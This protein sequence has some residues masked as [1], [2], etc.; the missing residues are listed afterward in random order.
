[1]P[2]TFLVYLLGQSNADGP[3][4]TDVGDL[5]VGYSGE[6]ENIKIWDGASNGFVNLDTALNNNQYPASERD[7]GFAIEMGML[8]DL[9]EYTGGQVY[10]IKYA[11]PGTPKFQRD[12]AD[13]NVGSVDDLFQ[14]AINEI[15][16]A[17]AWLTNNNILY[18]K[19][20]KVEWQGESDAL[21]T[22][23]D[24]QA[25]QQNNI[26]FHSAINT[27]IG[28]PMIDTILHKVHEDINAEASRLAA[29]RTAFDNI[30]SSELIPSVH[31]LN[32]DAFDLADNYHL[33]SADMLTQG[34]NVALEL[35]NIVQNKFD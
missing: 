13:W 4:T 33:D 9:A 32:V 23:A 2:H 24:A 3:P 30:L 19:L 10:C 18:T 27:Q 21:G 29:V 31:L 14:D 7:D 22:L 20:A 28:I 17:H 8:V 35:I 5:T 11:V 25:F 16:L 6:F 15:S 12:L 34:K 1:M 26:D